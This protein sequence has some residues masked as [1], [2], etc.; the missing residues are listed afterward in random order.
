MMAAAQAAAKAKIA[1]DIAHDKDERVD[2][3]E[4]LKKAAEKIKASK[5]PKTPKPKNK[6]GEEKGELL[7][8]VKTTIGESLQD[9]VDTIKAVAEVVSDQVDDIIDDIKSEEE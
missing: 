5:K 7:S 2:D 8:A 9:V 3:A 6:E 4:Q 1:D